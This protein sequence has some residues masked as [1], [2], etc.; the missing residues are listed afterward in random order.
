[1]VKV[2]RIKKGINIIFGVTIFLLLIFSGI[3]FP[4]VFISSN[5]AEANIPITIAFIVV[6]NIFICFNIGI[7][8]KETQSIIIE[9]IE[10]GEKNTGQ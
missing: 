8:R 2:E 4:N 9:E 10:R 7:K 1:M 5:L 3:Q 6:F